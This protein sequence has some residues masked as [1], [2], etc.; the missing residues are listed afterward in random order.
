MSKI[1][2][3]IYMH[4]DGSDDPRAIQGG[5]GRSA[6]RIERRTNSLWVIRAYVAV[7]TAR[8]GSLFTFMR[9]RA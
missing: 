4:E 7:L 6:R 2:V 8:D 5:G 3:D 9:V 1:T